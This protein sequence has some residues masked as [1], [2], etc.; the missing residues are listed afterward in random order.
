MEECSRTTLSTA[1][2]EACRDLQPEQ[3]VPV[4]PDSVMIYVKT[5]IH[6]A[7]TILLSTLGTIA[8]IINIIVY[9]SNGFKDSVNITFVTL[10]V[11]DLNVCVFTLLHS[12]CF[13]ID[14]YFPITQV[15]TMH[16][17]YVYIAYTKGFMYVLSTLVTVHLS[18]ERCVC[19]T[20][21]FKV[22]DILT[23]PRVILVNLIITMFGLG[24]YCPAWATQG[25]IWSTDPGTNM[26]RLVLW[27]SAN[28]RYVDLFIDTFNGIVILLLSQLLISLSAWF[29]IQSMNKSTKFRQQ[30]VSVQKPESYREVSSMNNV[31]VMTNKD[32]KL[33]KVVITLSLIF[34]VCN[35]PV[36]IVAF[37]RALMPEIDVGKSQHN[38]YGVLYIIVYLFGI[39]NSS[40]NII[41][42]HQVSTRYR[43]EFRKL[44]GLAYSVMRCHKIV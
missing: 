9:C 6:I 16:I 34:F 29:M 14:I 1:R 40:V 19:M 13:I 24:C 4:I 17:L 23:T 7:F 15:K 21:P 41:V 36:L 18:V 38:L 3:Y 32:V 25:L 5:Y 37:L 42:Y 26:T 11:W 30:A 39:I 2:H 44:F 8:N 31:K 10:S 20:F 28:R 22:K 27:V 43:R 35:L 12:V 33:T